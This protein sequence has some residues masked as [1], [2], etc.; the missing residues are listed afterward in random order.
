MNGRMNEHTGVRSSVNL[1]IFWRL[2][3]V[4]ERR[5][6]IAFIQLHK[7]I[8]LLLTMVCLLSVQAEAVKWIP[9]TGPALGPIVRSVVIDQ[10]AP[11]I[12]YAGTEV[13]GLYKSKDNGVSW[14]AMNTGLTNLNIYSVA[15]D[16]TTPSTLYAGTNGGG[17]FKSTDSGVN[18]A[19]INAGLT[20]ANIYAVAIDP[21]TPAILYTG[22]FGGVF[23]SM[24]GGA[25][26]LAIN[27]GLT[28]TMIYSVAI[29][30]N[31]PAILYAGTVGG[32][33]FKSTD[34]GANWVAI[35]TGLTNTIIYSVVID[36]LTSSTLYAG[37]NAGVFKSTDSGA[38]WGAI[39]TGLTA[40]TVYSIAITPSTP[41]TLFAGTNGGVFKSADSGANWGAA[42]TGLTNLT[43][44]SVA[45]DPIRA[46]TLYAGTNGNGVQTGSNTAPVGSVTID[47][48]NVVTANTT[49]TLALTCGDNVACSQMQ[50]SND[51]TAWSALEANGANKTWM[52][53]T[54]VDGVRTVYARF[55]D[56]AGNISNAAN[57]TI[58]LDTQPPAAPV[59]TAPGNNVFTNSTVRPTISGTAEVNASI[60]VKD[61]A[62]SLG[63]IT[64]TAG[65]WS[66]APGGALLSGGA[67]SFSARATDQA[68]NSGAASLVSTYVVHVT[69]P[70]ITLNG[71]T[72][73]SVEAGSVYNDAKATVVD[74]IGVTNTLLAG[75]SSVNTALPGA[76]T[77]TYNYTDAATNAAVAVVRTVNVVDTTGPV[78][79][80]PANLILMGDVVLG[81]VAVTDAQIVTFL[82]NGSATDI[83]DGA[84]MPTNNA[85]ALFAN[86]SATIV[87]FSAAD[88][89]GNTSTGSATV[90]ITDPTATGKN[91]PAPSGNGLTI[92][93]ALALGFDPNAA[94]VDADGDGIPD[95]VE[96]GDPANPY[97]QDGDGLIDAFE[98]GANTLDASIAAGLPVA[99]GTV[100]ISSPGQVISNV[101]FTSVGAGQPAGISFPFGVVSYDTSVAVGTSQT[102]TLSFSNALPANLELYKVDNAG[103]Y[104]L[105]PKGTGVNQWIQLNGNSIALTLL[106]GGLFD[107][108]RAANGVIVD[109][110]GVGSSSLVV[111]KVIRDGGCVMSPVRN[112]VDPLFPV[113]VV[114]SICYLVLRRYQ[115]GL[116]KVR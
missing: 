96:V 104:S 71:V 80:A 58:T 111:A 22:T 61:G 3:A 7:L 66:L 2:L 110:V 50:F 57:D 62:I 94:T 12:L 54:G 47:N 38:N 78:V 52:M 42:N 19:A 51:N 113:M 101:A 32:G 82:N 68:G 115:S 84:V 76:Y 74:N 90:T 73:I 116:G 5:I 108:D 49:V 44:W 97:D 23:K 102:I 72:P 60:E 10:G 35:N 85:P 46:A 95:A 91:A 65:N 53:S 6:I 30:P 48:G 1:T 25:N 40:T 11:N 83:V 114:L 112:S 13:G 70:V 100:N 9:A 56:A 69:L 88:A 20:N 39:N 17:L 86:G 43:I 75:V 67:H 103:A 24:D 28:N 77:V 87:T 107:L 29:D 41:A 89:L 109:P 79:T 31:R 45:I 15:I 4:K 26:W 93:Q 105:I 63:L 99:S 14:T 55:T 98:T 27:A 106:D 33:V 59:I 34:S 64:A 81:G 16:Q 36:P 8:L 18:W 37:T 21:T 92:A